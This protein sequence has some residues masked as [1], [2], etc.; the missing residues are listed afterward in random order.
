LIFPRKEK[1]P[2]SRSPELN[3]RGPSSTVLTYE[4]RR[5][6]PEAEKRLDQRQAGVKAPF[7]NRATALPLLTP[8]I[9]LLILS[10]H[11]LT[12]PALA[13][14]EEAPSWQ[15][16]AQGEV[17]CPFRA[18][19]DHYGAGGHAGIDIAL[20]KASS[21]CATESG[22]VTFAGRT[23]LGSCVSV[24]HEG[25]FKSTYV[26]L[27]SISVRAGDAVDRGQLVGASD[28]CLDKSSSAPHL[29][30]GLFLNGLPIDP[31]PL[32]QGLTLDPQ[33]CLFLGPWEDSKS[34][35]AYVQRHNQGSLF[36]WLG[37]G[38]KAIGGGLASAF[39]ET[40]GAV[41]R[42][43]HSVWKGT[44][45]AITSA[46]KSVGKA[47]SAFYRH[48]IKPWLAPFCR[49]VAAVAKKAWSNRY[50]QALAA[51]LAAAAVV[52]L[53]VVGVALL[54]GAS[55]VAT[56]VA[57]ALGSLAAVGYALYYA[58]TSGDSFSFATC[59]LSSLAVG[60][61]AGLSS[62]LLSFM[63]PLIAN[64]WANIGF[65]GFAKGFLIHGFLDS[66]AYIVLCLATGRQVAPMGVLAS[67]LLGGLMGAF[68][69]LFMAGLFS[70]GSME[71][72]AAGWLS[73]GGG[74]LSGE[75]AAGISAYASALMARFTQKL[76]YVFFCGCTGF[77]GDLIIRACVGGRPSVLESLLSFTGGFVLGS[78]SLA[79]NGQGVAGLLTRLTAGKLK[80]SSEVARAIVGKVF[81]WS[82]KDAFPALVRKLK[83]GRHVL[84]RDPWWSEIGGDM[85]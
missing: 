83:G 55:I 41:G 49:G 25:G 40:G 26:N 33:E 58:A 18:S 84:K 65:L 4:G 30:F 43:L 59:F 21:V 20:A 42:A 73:S 66:T 29:H 68:G 47:L 51:G 12:S 15:W 38:F 54:I 78:V 36:S 48:C 10:F 74:F 2:E 60:G 69:K 28:G 31:L 35:E 50:V 56:V 77:L 79:A 24:S 11:L 53:A 16:P 57:A 8:L 5:I 85:Q 46:G 64:G 7:K 9:S 61:A 17:I 23:P 67:F 39:K 52:V 70:E 6:Q 3:P 22:R 27:Q 76:A 19:Q 32:L 82:L 71:V 81:S 72:L 75:G 37:R 1:R 34:L 14:G 80:F 63:A 45:G 44:W 13:A 62:L